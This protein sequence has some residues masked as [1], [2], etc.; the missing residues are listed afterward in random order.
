MPTVGSSWKQIQSFPAP[1]NAATGIVRVGDTLWVTVPCDNHIF[2]LDLKGN[3]ISELDMPEPGCGPGEVGL[4]WDGSSL[5]G[6][7]GEQAIQIDPDTGRIISKFSADLEGSSLAWDGSSLWMA[8][9]AG[10]LSVYQP[11]GTRQRRLAIPGFI[12]GITWADGELWELDEW[13]ALTRFDQDLLEV[14]SFSLSNGCGI[15][16]FHRQMAFGLFWD[17]ASLWVADAVNDRIYQCAPGK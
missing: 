7:W 14:D 16:S 17:E 13:G 10:T 1:G 9:H 4:A 11:N 12:T 8:N 3:I 15:S 6:T 5:W 2:H